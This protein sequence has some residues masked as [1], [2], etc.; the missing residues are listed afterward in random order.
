MLTEMHYL[1]YT[2]C[3]LTGWWHVRV[4]NKTKHVICHTFYYKL[5]PH[6]YANTWCHN[7]M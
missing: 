1:S 4:Y 7:S 5:L 6:S 2:Y 3:S